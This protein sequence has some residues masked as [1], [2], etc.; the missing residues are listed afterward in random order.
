[1]G[2]QGAVDGACASCLTGAGLQA[3]ASLLLLVIAIL[4]YTYNTAGPVFRLKT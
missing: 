1:V 3:Q 4:A 2:Q